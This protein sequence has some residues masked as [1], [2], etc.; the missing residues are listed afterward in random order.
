[1]IK[2]V[3]QRQ[4]WWWPQTDQRCWDYMQSHP[5]VPQLISEFVPIDQRRV[6]VQ[7]GGNCGFYPRQYAELFD[8]VYT[9][10]PDWLNFYCLNLNV[11]NSNVVKIQS[12]L[13]DKHQTVGLNIK[14]I[15]RGKNFVDGSGVY[16]M[17]R[18]DDLALDQ[19]DLIQLDIEGYE[20]Y[21]LLGAA[22]TIE[23]FHPVIVVEVWEQLKNRF[24]GNINQKLDDFLQ[25]MGYT[26]T[27]TLYD[28]DRVYQYH[29]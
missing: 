16:P 13:G 5:D 1:M 29:P 15:N 20:Y 2:D 28:S 9:F 8:R 23:Q 10:E 6:V 17:L 27:K 25:S 14:S 7:A 21:A 19:C 22:K 12:C 24:D 26:L 18:I 4:G 3:E 11:P